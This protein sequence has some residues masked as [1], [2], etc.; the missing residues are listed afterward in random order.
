M[1]DIGD[2]A[3]ELTIL[4]V[5]HLTPVRGTTTIQFWPIQQVRGEV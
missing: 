3:L 5:N 2:G 1:P 4:R